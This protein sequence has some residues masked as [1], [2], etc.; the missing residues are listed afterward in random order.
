M[1]SVHSS[2]LF[3]LLACFLVLPGIAHA[4]T[5]EPPILSVSGQGSAQGSPDQAVVTISVTN[6]AADAKTVQRENAARAGTI[7]KALQELGIPTKDI[8][9][10]NYSFHPTYRREAGY[11]NEIS[12]YQA[13]NSILVTVNEF[14][15]VGQVID[16]ALK[17]GANQIS[18]LDFRIRNTDKLRREALTA[19]I[20]DARGK[21]DI[22][23][24]GLGKRITGIK[25]VSEST[26]SV[27]HRSHNMALMAKAESMD[28][29]TP[30]EAGMLS[31]DASV[32][33]DFI[34][35]D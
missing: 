33:I 14:G 24:Q 32:H 9:T 16:T 10:R 26:G 11:E 21:A 1:K 2:I 30:I 35:G 4:A 3:L 17:S 22:I 29:G 31:L 27:G 6:H 28:M 25:S 8:Q 7:Q 19:A 13:N 15:L 23:A 18:S 12:G 5:S 20:R 34:L